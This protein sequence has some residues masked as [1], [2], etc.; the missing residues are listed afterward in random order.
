MRLTGKKAAIYVNGIKVMDAYDCT[1]RMGTSTVTGNAYG[2][3]WDHNVAMKS[4][5]T[6]TAKKYAS[7]QNG[8]GHFTATHLSNINIDGIVRVLLY[9]DERS[10]ATRVFEGWGIIT[11]SDF[12]PPVGGLVEE[13]LSITGTQN[14]VFVSGITPTGD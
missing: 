6:F 11:E 1:V 8:Q 10:T 7:V 3:D 12:T 14:P 13:T 4:N 9:Q 5:W 2:E